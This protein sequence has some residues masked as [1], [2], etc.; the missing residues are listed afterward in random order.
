MEVHVRME[1][2]HLSVNALLDSLENR[3]SVARHFV[4]NVPKTLCA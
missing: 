4:P 2:P 1:S 3:V